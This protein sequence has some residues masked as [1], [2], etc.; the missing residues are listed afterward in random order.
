MEDN[1]LKKQFSKMDCFLKYWASN[2]VIVFQIGEKFGKTIFRNSLKK[3]CNN[4][5][6]KRF[7]VFKEKIEII[8]FAKKF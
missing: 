8:L 1:N 6:G 3:S 4:S 7:H 5:I 2:R